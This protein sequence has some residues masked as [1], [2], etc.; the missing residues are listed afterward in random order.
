MEKIEPGKNDRKEMTNILNRYKVIISLVTAVMTIALLSSPLFVQAQD[1]GSYP[2][3]NPLGLTYDGDFNPISSNVSVYGAINN[4]ESCI[5]DADRKLIIVP[6]RGVSQR[7]Q[8]NDAWVSL[9]NSDGSVHTTK[10]IGVQN[11]GQRSELSPP[12]VL[13][14]PL[15]S[16]IAD[17]VLYFADRDGGTSQDDPTVAVIRRFDLETG[18]PLEDIRLEDSPWI[19]DIAV[20]KD[21][22]IYTTQ[23]GDLGQNPDPQSW[24]VWKVSP[25]GDISEFAVGEPINIP[26]G[27][28]LDSD[29]NIVVVNFGNPEVLTFSPEGELLKTEKAVQAGGDGIEIM[30]DG[31]KYVSSVRQGGITRISPNGSAELIAENI[32]SAASI[33]YDSDAN[34][35]VVPMT[36]QSTLGFVPLD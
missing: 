17:G 27:I 31:T 8:V 29:G 1:T 4:A 5:Y 32:P 9:I 11:P 22:T 23:T 10:W 2:V 26:N 24:K 13:N 35:L 20:A 21:G 15:G 16:E 33:C 34:Q 18:A 28:A 25:Q 14:D 36:S 6:S 30:P 12:L 7:V 3:G 19:N